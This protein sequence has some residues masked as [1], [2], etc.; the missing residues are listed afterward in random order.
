M[1][2]VDTICIFADIAVDFDA[3]HQLVGRLVLL[4]PFF[5]RVLLL[6]ENL[7]EFLALAIVKKLGL[8]A[9]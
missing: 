6:L 1:V 4:E 3:L 7:I 5:K 2:V 8:R 9:I